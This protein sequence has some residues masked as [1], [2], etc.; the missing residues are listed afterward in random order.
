MDFRELITLRRSR[1]SYTD[2]AIPETALEA[3]VEAGLLAPTGRNLHPCEIIMVRE[4]AMLAQLARAKTGGS[5]MLAEAGAALVVVG[6][7]TRSDTWVEDGSIMMAYM[8]LAAEAQGV[9]NCWVQIRSRQSQEVLANGEHLSSDDYV[10]AA[11][12]IPESYAVLAILALGMSEEAR[13][14]HTAADID[15]SKLHDERF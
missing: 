10:R 12:D 14:P 11:L 6:N 7:T 15:K 13:P 5:A 1:R 2:A 4:K 9:G 8:Q 3:I